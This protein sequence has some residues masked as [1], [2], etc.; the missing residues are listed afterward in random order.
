MT[1]LTHSPSL[2]PSQNEAPDYFGL[3]T[4]S[5]GSPDDQSSLKRSLLKKLKL[6]KLLTISL[7]KSPDP[8]PEPKHPHPSSTARPLTVT[9]PSLPREAISLPPLYAGRMP[10]YLATK[11]EADRVPP[12]KTP[13]RRTRKLCHQKSVSSAASVMLVDHTDSLYRTNTNNSIAS[14]PNIGSAHY[15]RRGAPSGLTFPVPSTATPLDGASLDM[16]FARHTPRAGSNKTHLIVVDIRPFEQYASLRIVGAV[17]ISLPSMLLKRPTYGLSQTLQTLSRLEQDVFARCLRE[18]EENIARNHRAVPQ[19][20]TV[21]CGPYGLPAVLIYDGALMSGGVQKVT[22][23]M[24]CMV[25]KFTA[26]NSWNAPV[27]VL[28]GGFNEFLARYPDWVDAGEAH[29]MTSY[30]QSQQEMERM[31]REQNDGFSFS[32]NGLHSARSSLTLDTA[33]ILSQVNLLALLEAF[34]ETSKASISSSELGGFSG[35]QLP[36]AQHVFRVRQNDEVMSIASCAQHVELSN[37]NLLTKDEAARLPQW[38]KQ[39]VQLQEDGRTYNNI[40]LV[41]HFQQI[42][43]LEKV[44][45]NG[46]SAGREVAIAGVERGLKNRYKD[47]LPFEETRVK[48]RRQNEDDYINASHLSSRWSNNRYIATQGPLK[49]T[50]G[51][52]WRM[53]VENNVPFIVALT[54][55]RDGFVEK[56]TDYWSSQVSSDGLVKIDLL[57][58]VRLVYRN[59]EGLVEDTNGGIFLRRVRVDLEGKTHDVMQMQ[60]KN[61]HDLGTFDNCEELLY[62][63]FLKRYIV[64]KYMEKGHRD[65][66]VV[67]HCLAGCGRTGTFCAIDAVV[68]CEMDGLAC[69]DEDRVFEVVKEFRKQRVSTVQTLRQYLLVYDVLLVFY[70]FRLR[71]G[72]KGRVGAECGV[73]GRFL[74]EEQNNSTNTY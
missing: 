50:V 35:F 26:N 14:L 66:P 40:R 24:S 55:E 8:P 36:V 57:E 20:G 67:V 59:G 43:T 44:R 31:R 6:Q 63:V 34:S 23:A 46:L 64:D 60:V 52:F 39:A 15:K 56:C 70:R 13:P 10:A 19:P 18:Q 3:R 73:V 27:F 53:V 69:G 72:S 62:C 37:L 5:L 51:D 45:M 16:F 22:Q 49:S 48:L 33:T 28:K 21:K 11:V 32:K 41:E 38:I 7:L 29:K 4:A 42:E 9:L 71:G 30:S 1:T 54:E 68:G 25:Q 2:S 58:T 12:L 17:N 61:W 47:V 65:F 74:S